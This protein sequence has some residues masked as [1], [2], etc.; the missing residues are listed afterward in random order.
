MALSALTDVVYVLRVARDA[1]S[2]GTVLDL[3]WGAAFLA[4]VLVLVAEGVEDVATVAALADLDCDVAQ[5]Y[6]VSR[7]LPPEQLEAWLAPAAASAHPPS[8]AETTT[9]PAPGVVPA[10]RCAGAA[11]LQG[12]AASL[13]AEGGEGSSR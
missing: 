10:W 9:R 12:P 13:R 6:H 7:P 3:G 11:P 2:G 8:P 4:V 5:G 1:H